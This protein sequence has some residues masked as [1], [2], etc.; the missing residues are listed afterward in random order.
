[1]KTVHASPD[2]LVV[3]DR[4]WGLIVGTHLVAIATILAALT[5]AGYGVWMRLFLLALGAGVLWGAWRLLPFVT[6]E[7]DR[8]A[9]TAALHHHRLTGTTSRTCPLAQLQSACS[10]AAVIEGTRMERVV[11]MLPD[12]PMPVEPG[13]ASI[14]RGA[15]AEEIN[16]WLAQPQTGR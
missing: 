8:T 2:R 3:A 5:D 11:L 9:G 12:G 10:Q 1:M 4:P 16:R 6:L 7:L 15:L 14:P 13:F